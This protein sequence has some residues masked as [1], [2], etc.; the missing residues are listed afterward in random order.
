[1]GSTPRWHMCVLASGRRCTRG[2]STV[3]AGSPARTCRLFLDHL[4]GLVV[5]EASAAVHRD[6]RRMLDRPRGARLAYVDA[7]NPVLIE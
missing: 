3:T 1:M 6:A 5:L 7:S 2:A 4:D